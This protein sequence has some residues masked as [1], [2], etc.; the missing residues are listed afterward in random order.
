M[1]RSGYWKVDGPWRMEFNAKELLN[2][3]CS[4]YANGINIPIMNNIFFNYD[5]TYSNMEN[6][7]YWFARLP[8]INYWLL[9]RHPIDNKGLR[10]ADAAD[11]HPTQRNP[12]PLK[13]P[14]K[15]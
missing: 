4:P 8:S 12:I 11:P 1:K 13:V 10:A 3:F 9:Y 2:G 14:L 15:V 5:G 7:K 6:R